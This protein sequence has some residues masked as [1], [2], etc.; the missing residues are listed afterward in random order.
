MSLRDG[1]GSIS[2][3]LSADSGRTRGRSVLDR[4]CQN[5]LQR[6]GFLGV[7]LR[8]FEPLTPCMPCKCSA[9]L[10]YS[11]VGG[12]IVSGF[13]GGGPELEAWRIRPEMLQVVVLPSLQVEEM[14][15]EVPVV[16]EHPPSELGPLPTQRSPALLP[17][18]FLHL[19]DERL[20]MAR[21]GAGG[22]EEQVGEDHELRHVEK[23]QVE[24]LLVFDG[25]RGTT[26]GG[27]RFSAGNDV[28]NPL[29]WGRPVRR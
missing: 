27:D 26:S 29:L 10:S 12:G 25:G 28:A 14:D 22:D 19:V 20:D 18:L 13:G 24:T 9:E 21:R 7:E 11:P 1:L 6:K 17:E 8:G 4:Q 15:D 23:R 16:E 2:R 5:P 3:G